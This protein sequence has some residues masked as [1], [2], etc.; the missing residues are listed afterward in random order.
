MALNSSGAISLGGCTV[1]ESIA[2]ELG[3]SGTASININCSE[4]R[5]L[6]GVPTNG[7]QISFSNFYGKSFSAGVGTFFGGVAAYPISNALNKATRINACGALIGVETTIGTARGITAGARVGAYGLFYGGLTTASARTSLVTRVNTCGALVGSETNVGTARYGLS[8]AFVGCNGLFYGGDCTANARKVTRINACGS[9]V[10]ASQTCLSYYKSYG[11]GAS[12]GSYGLFYAGCE[13]TNPNISV[14][15]VRRINGCGNQVGSDTQVGQ[16]R[17]RLAGTKVGT[18]GLFYGGVQG[19][20]CC[21]CGFL[22]CFAWTNTVTRINACGSLVGSETSITP[23]RGQHGA[24][25]VGSN[26]IF[27]G[28]ICY[29][30]TFAATNKVIRINACGA[31]VGSE[32]TAGSNRFD[33][34]GNSK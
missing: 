30:S 8:G 24:S 34:A 20:Y 4:V 15:S 7:A 33:V 28:G 2:K 19:Y 1:G 5:T 21:A 16:N 10:G 31:Q 12:A 6:G 23:Q 26:G 14:Q 17:S 22:C 32:T 27:Y 29:N 13:T 3:R 25:T 11:A 18:N 9:L